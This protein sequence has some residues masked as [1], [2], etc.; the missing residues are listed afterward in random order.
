MH[1]VLAKLL[2]ALLVLACLA[3]WVWL[4]IAEWHRQVPHWALYVG[5]VLLLVTLAGLGHLL[6]V[7]SRPGDDGVRF[8]EH[9]VVRALALTSQ[10]DGELVLTLE[11]VRELAPA[12]LAVRLRF[13]GVTRMGLQQLGNW[14][15]SH[16]GLRIQPMR[17]GRR[18]GMRFRVQDRHREALSLLC[19][20]IHEEK[21]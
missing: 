1:P 6:Q 12:A 16:D 20:E 17:P 9:R 8:A 21:A 14:P 13:V 7:H 15:L 3:G 11:L 4:V 2:S 5:G 19:R 10:G 18:D